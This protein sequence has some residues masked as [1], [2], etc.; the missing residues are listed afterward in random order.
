MRVYK[1][2]FILLLLVS[3]QI[4]AQEV[5][6]KSTV[7][8]LMAKGGSLS[9]A[10]TAVSNSGSSLSSASVAGGVSDIK[11]ASVAGSPGQLYGSEMSKNLGSSRGSEG[12]SAKTGV[13]TAGIPSETVV[14]GS[15]DP[16][17]IRKILIDNILLSYI[18]LH[19]LQ[20]SFFLFH[21]ID[22]III[23]YFHKLCHV[24]S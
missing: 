24:F 8:K 2:I 9:G 19:L 18:A 14:R 21:Q 22:D 5:S 20:I 12:L 7:S 6:F 15:M 3:Q 10:R 1:S 4:T 17:V 11:K 16:D 13:Y 23:Y